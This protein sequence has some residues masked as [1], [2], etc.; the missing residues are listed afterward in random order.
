MEEERTDAMIC[1]MVWV[2][3]Q[4]KTGQR[5]IRIVVALYRRTPGWVGGTLNEYRRS[6]ERDDVVFIIFI[7]ERLRERKPW[8][9][10]DAVKKRNAHR[11][12]V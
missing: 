1:S 4:T 8:Q 2:N 3:R 11:C 10:H 5:F 12:T 9:T 6:I 7:G